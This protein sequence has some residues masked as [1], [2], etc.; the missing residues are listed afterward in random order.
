MVPTLS[1]HRSPL[2][3]IKLFFWL[4]FPFQMIYPELNSAFQVRRN[5]CF[6]FKHSYSP[7]SF[8]ILSFHC[9]WDN[10]TPKL[11]SAFRWGLPTLTPFVTACGYTSSRTQKCMQILQLLLVY[12]VF[13][14]IVLTN[15]LWFGNTFCSAVFRNPSAHTFG[16]LQHFHS[17]ETYLFCSRLSNP[18]LPQKS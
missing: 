3:N 14:N 1:L 18:K 15:I 7:H 12:R 4:Q 10:T 17:Q 11:F 9:T 16:G 5:H 8:F 13:L 6:L 2:I